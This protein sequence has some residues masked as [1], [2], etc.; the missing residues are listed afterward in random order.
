MK[1]RHDYSRYDCFNA[2]DVLKLRTI[3]RQDIREFIMKAGEYCS[4]QDA[5]QIVCRVDKDHDGR[6]TYSEFCDFLD[7]GEEARP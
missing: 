3:M 6:I 1:A 7:E 2:C 5:D 4:V